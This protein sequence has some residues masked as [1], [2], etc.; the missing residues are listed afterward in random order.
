MFWR[1]VVRQDEQFEQADPSLANGKW[2]LQVAGLREVYTMLGSGAS[3][4]GSERNHLYFGGLPGG[5]F[6]EVSVVSGLDDP[7]DTRAFAL[8][9]LDR[10]GWQDMVLAGLSGPRFRLMR[11]TLGSAPAGESNGFV[12]LRFVG[13]NSTSQPSEQW[14]ARDGFG[15]RVELALPDGRRIVRTHRVDDG[16]KAQH[17]STM[18]VGLGPVDNATVVVRWPSGAVTRVGNVA[19]GALVTAHENP[20]STQDGSGVVA[21]SYRVR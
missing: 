10:D 7:G 14:T 6:A 16:F 12:A 2:R 5:Q 3:W 8:L 4:S 18:I 11:N 19:S 15:A 1:T 21:T 9:D 20:A 17:S 13:G